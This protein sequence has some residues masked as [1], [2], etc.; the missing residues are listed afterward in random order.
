MFALKALSHESIP[1]AIA[2]AEHYRFLKE[3]AEAESICRDVLDV[4][5][6]NQRAL[7]CFVLAGS[8]QLKQEP[9][10]FHNALAAA[11]KIEGAYEKAYYSGILWERRAKAQL[12]DRGRGTRHSVYE[13]MVKALHCFGEAERL[14]PPGNDDA[15]LRWNTCV[16][17]LAKH[18]HLAPAGE[19]APEPIVSE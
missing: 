1:G 15:L 7:I 6:G 11:A 9:K 3:P 13:W 2:R 19:E 8:D 18:P 4:E 17:F 16:R 5:P 10:A 14:R 12:E